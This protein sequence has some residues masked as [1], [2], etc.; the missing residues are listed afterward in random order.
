MCPPISVQDWPS[1]FERF[2][3]F[4]RLFK[5]PKNVGVAEVVIRAVTLGFPQAFFG[6]SRIF[7]ASCG[8]SKSV[9]VEVKFFLGSFLV[10]SSAWDD[11]P[12]HLATISRWFC[13]T[14]IFPISQWP[15][16]DL[17]ILAMTSISSHSHHWCYLEETGRF[18][19]ISRMIS[20]SSEGH[21]NIWCDLAAISLARLL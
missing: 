16:N 3:W 17:E 15:H 13:S 9:R 5:A 19:N 18:S 7:L 21:S 11:I 20:R 1:N 4:M 14:T 10:L 2:L 12:A 8:H 6:Y